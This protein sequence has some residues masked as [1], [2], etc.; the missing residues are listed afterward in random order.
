MGSVHRQLIFLRHIIVF[1]KVADVGPSTFGQG[2]Q[3]LPQ[4]AISLTRSSGVMLH[5]QGKAVYQIA[6]RGVD[7]QRPDGLER[8]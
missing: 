2:S 1:R 5:L 8:H 4:D 7:V 3:A 6:R